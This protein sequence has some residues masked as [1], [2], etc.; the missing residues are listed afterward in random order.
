MLE[1]SLMKKGTTSLNR[2]FSLLF[3]ISLLY[4][5]EHLSVDE[6][7]PSRK[8]ASGA[9]RAPNQ[10]QTIWE[11]GRIDLKLR[12]E[13]Y[14]RKFS[15]KINEVEMVTYL[16][17][18]TDYHNET[19]EVGIPGLCYDFNCSAFQGKTPLWDLVASGPK[20]SK[21]PEKLVDAIRGLG[22]KPAENLVSAGYFAVKPLSWMAFVDELKRS[23]DANILTKSNLT[24][25]TVENRYD[26]LMNL[27]FLASECKEA[28]T[29]C[30]IFLEKIIPTPFTAT[31]EKQK[32]KTL[33]SKNIEG[34]ITVKG[35]KLLPHEQ[36]E[37]HVFINEK[38]EV[39]LEVTS[40]LNRYKIETTP[41]LD[42]ELRIYVTQIDRNQV[43]LPENI[44]IR[45]SLK[46]E[47][48]EVIWRAQLNPTYVP[49]RSDPDSQ[50][51]L[52]YKVKICKNG[53]FGCGLQPWKEIKSDFLVLNKST[54][55]LP[56]TI[57]KG[58]KVMVTYTLARSASLF[59]NSNPTGV[60][61]TEVLQTPSW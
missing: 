18:Y 31:R 53:L 33:Q 41:G 20:D 29:E 25:I 5:C 60:R 39:S 40:D 48:D 54:V 8:L 36:E 19:K 43:N 59:Y 44:F 4:S 22:L 45:D 49:N 57:P 14:S 11:P 16:Q 9:S 10:A 46:F 28:I 32:R 58:Y 51:I 15:A 30:T 56:L 23:V 7:K 1:K 35:T 42:G 24:K 47:K 27:G 2:T 34:T 13:N 12:T 6:K 37:L 55:E 26:N 52:Q 38:M 50:L 61:Q 17:K 3:L 21:T